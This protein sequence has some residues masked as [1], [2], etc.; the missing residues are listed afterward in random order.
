MLLKVV[1]LF[2]LG[3][4][5]FSFFFTG[6]GDNISHPRNWCFFCWK[7]LRADWPRPSSSCFGLGNP[8]GFKSLRGNS[9]SA[10]GFSRMKLLLLIFYI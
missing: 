8:D 6:L 7:G 9:T 10:C 3:Y 2:F 1:L 5:E 4:L